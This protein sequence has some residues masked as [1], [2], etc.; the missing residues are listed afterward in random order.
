M[1]QGPI[2]IIECPHCG[3]L[4]KQKSVHS[5]NPYGAV[6]W[7]DGKKVF[8]M[9]NSNP[10]ITKCKICGKF[11]FVKDAAEIAQAEFTFLKQ[12]K[13]LDDIEFIEFLSPDE[14]LEAVLS[15]VNK[16]LKDEIY[17]RI[18]FWWLYN[19]LF[20][21]PDEVIKSRKIITNAIESYKEK[22]NG[23]ILRLIEILPDDDEEYVV[24]KAELYRQIGEFE[25]CISLLTNVPKN[26]L[27]CASQ[28]KQKAI[29]NYT[30]VIILDDKG[31]DE[32]CLTT[33]SKNY[34]WI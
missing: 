19:D 3:H 32:N 15:P 5:V 27:Q 2:I 17:L 11:Y 21:H 22:N 16:S 24:M 1:L 20:R 26:F 6:L 18:Q 28:I 25:K 8:P 12:N 13:I 10:Q 30:T 34:I 23:N 4:A 31:Q 29:E 9:H 14:Y 7:S 33:D